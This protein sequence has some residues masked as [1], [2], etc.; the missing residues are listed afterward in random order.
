MVPK[1]MRKQA[2]RSMASFAPRVVSR[3]GLRPA[4]SS[5]LL[6]TQTRTYATQDDSA[7][8]IDAQVDKALSIIT[9]EGGLAQGEKLTVRKIVELRQQIPELDRTLS[10]IGNYGVQILS[11]AAGQPG[12]IKEVP[13][14]RVAVTGAAGA[15]GYAL[16]F[17]IAS[18]AMLGPHQPVILQ[19]LE[20]PQGLKPLEG[21]AMELKDC[22]FPLL[23]G[24]VQ[25]S[26]PNEAF[27]GADFALLVGAKPRTK[28][29]ERGD[30]L[31]ENANIFSVQGKALNAHANRDT[32]RVLVVG[33]PANTNALIASCYAPNIHPRRFTAMTR[34]DH[35]RGLAQLADKLNV[36]TTDIERFC[37]WGNHSATQYPDVS[38]TL[39]NGKPAKEL[40]DQKWIADTFIPKVQ[41]RGAEII[42]ARGSSSAASAANAA[43]E[44]MRDWVAG[45][46]GQWTSMGVWTGNGQAGD[47]STSPD[48]YYS[49]PVVCE[50]GDY[51]IV[52]NVPIDKF[53]ADR[54]QK[55]NDEL[56]S[57]KNAIANLA[58]RQDPAELIKQQYK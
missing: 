33:N 22:A 53:S 41:Q 25:T 20:I 28:G 37:I 55:T 46:N 27:A 21:V 47:Y 26:D 29:M 13:P 3:S 38:H 24:I 44:H 35:N 7:A 18:G 6:R 36:K 2:F 4:V 58:K 31:K 23:R 43:I 32:L 40:L 12:K 51:T 5:M 39:I 1:M 49:F 17:R 56:V 50:N 52:Q 19:L 16:L 14:V 15:I 48:I 8:S 42:N 9:K 10:N 11:R 54:M 30:L 57:E 34:L 45:T